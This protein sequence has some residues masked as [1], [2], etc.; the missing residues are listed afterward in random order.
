MAQPWIGRARFLFIPLIVEGVAGWDAPP[1]DFRELVRRRVYF[2]P[3]PGL[4]FTLPVEPGDGSEIRV[5]TS[6]EREKVYTTHGK[7]AFEVEH[8]AGVD[9]RVD[10]VGGSKGPGVIEAPQHYRKQD[11]DN[12][13]E[14]TPR[15]RALNQ[16][17]MQW[18]G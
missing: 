7:V 18:H 6:D 4:I 9:V 3:D 5:P 14:A 15:P 2:D 16:A 10:S 17:S 8:V 11:Q 12:D 13:V 1:A